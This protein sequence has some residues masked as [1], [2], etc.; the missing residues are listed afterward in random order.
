[1]LWPNVR[2]A[3]CSV[4]LHRFYRPINHNTFLVVLGASVERRQTT[5]SFIRSV[6]P[7]VRV[8]QLGSHWTDFHDVL[9]W[10]LKICRE[11][12]RLVKSDQNYRDLSVET[13]KRFVRLTTTY[14]AHQ[15]CQI[16][17]CWVS[18]EQRLRERARNTLLR[19]YYLSCFCLLILIPVSCFLLLNLI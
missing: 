19:G 15:Q 14:R 11:I 5:I 9:C 12:W 8:Y 17:H 3:G 2:A 16:T 1:M 4:L 10:G 13:Y 18:W 6:R 7:S